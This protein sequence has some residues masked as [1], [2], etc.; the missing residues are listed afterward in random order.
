[1]KK[2][3]K[4][5]V[6]NISE[7]LSNIRGFFAG[8]WQMYVSQKDIIYSFTGFNHFAMARKYCDRR[9][10]RS[11]KRHYVIPAGRGSQQLIVFNSVEGKQLKR[12]GL[13]N[14]RVT[15]EVLLRDAYYWS[16]S[17]SLSVKP[18]RLSLFQK[19]K[20]YSKTIKFKKS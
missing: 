6:G 1:M 5:L 2:R 12:L 17:R 14:K 9:T 20:A 16:S 11:G 13:M 3:L 10:K 19:L 8:F 4:T 7:F 15:I 18:V